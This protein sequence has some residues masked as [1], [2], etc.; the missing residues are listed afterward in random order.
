MH[1]VVRVHTWRRHLMQ[2]LKIRNKPL[3]DI[4]SL[5]SSRSRAHM[6]VVSC[7]TWHKSYIKGWERSFCVV[8]EP[9]KLSRPTWLIS[10]I[11]SK[12]LSEDTIKAANE[13]ICEHKYVSWHYHT[14]ITPITDALKDQLIDIIKQL[15]K[16]SLKHLTQSLI[17]KHLSVSGQWDNQGFVEFWFL[18]NFLILGQ[19][20]GLLFHHQ[21]T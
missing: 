4:I 8:E 5:S 1:Y 9:L 10:Y 17:V 21:P 13:K 3:R 7:L 11:V 18:S 6:S 20:T 2:F 15:L 14:L 12:F 19:T 16:E